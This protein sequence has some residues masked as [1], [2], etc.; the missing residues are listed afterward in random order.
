MK[1]TLLINFL[2]ILFPALLFQPIFV[3]CNTIHL[4]SE[5][6]TIDKAKYKLI[7]RYHKHT[8]KESQS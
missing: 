1:N 2:V 8:F 6:N 7:V 5:G 4:D 3:F